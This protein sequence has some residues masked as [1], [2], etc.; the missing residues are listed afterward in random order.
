MFASILS[1]KFSSVTQ[2]WIGMSV[3]CS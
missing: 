3:L 1:L 2:Y